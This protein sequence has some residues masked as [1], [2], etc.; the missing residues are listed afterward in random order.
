MNKGH[1]K[2]LYNRGIYFQQILND[3]QYNI[4]NQDIKNEIICIY[5]IKTYNINKNINLLNYFESDEELFKKYN[6]KEDFQ[7]SID[8]FIDN[9]KIDFQFNYKFPKENKYNLTIK[10]KKLL[11]NL[12]NMFYNCSSLSSLNLSNFNTNNVQDMNNMFYY[13]SSLT[14]FHL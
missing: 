14:S 11:Q 5:D 3:I 7:N 9:Q 8:L 6:N 1:F 2:D 4:S 13:C 12:R 10:I